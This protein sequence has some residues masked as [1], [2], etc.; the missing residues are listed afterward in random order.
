M[1][2]FLLFFLYLCLCTRVK[3][4][5]YLFCYIKQPW[6]PQV[7]CFQGRIYSQHSWDTISHGS[8]SM[9]YIQRYNVSMAV[10]SYVPRTRRSQGPS[11]CSQGWVF[12]GF[13]FCHVSEFLCHCKMFLCFFFR[14]EYLVFVPKQWKLWFI[15]HRGGGVLNSKDGGSVGH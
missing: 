3:R 12:P 10:Y 7:L 1:H 8:E 11:V 15:I 14:P 9:S 5:I 4:T 2:P 13:L 6:V